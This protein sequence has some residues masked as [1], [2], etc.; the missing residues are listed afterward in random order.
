MVF[1]LLNIFYHNNETPGICQKEAAKS[2]EGAEETNR[3][4]VW[5]E[6]K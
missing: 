3:Q 4:T 6:L 5:A 2:R 1:Y